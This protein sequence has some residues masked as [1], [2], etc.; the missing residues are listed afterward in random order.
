MLSILICSSKPGLLEQVKDNINTT[1]GVEYELLFIDNR[2]FNKG[3]CS[4]Y[5]TLADMAKYQHLCFLHE[6][7]LFQTKG[8]G[9]I[10]I[11]IFS[12]DPEIGLIGLA[13]CKYKS[14]YFSGWFSNVKELD[15]A[16]YIH[17]YETGVEKVFLSPSGD[18]SLQ[19]VVCIDGVFM[20][21]KKEAWNLN[22]FNEGLLKGFH[23][24]DIDFSLNIAHH[25]KVMVT[26]DLELMHITSGGDYGNNWVETAMKYHQFMKNRLP[27]SKI[28]V[29]L[30][31]TD[32]E[33]I[34]ATLD[35]LK[36][37]KISISNKIKWLTLQKLYLFPNFYYSILK[38]LFYN[39]L[40]LRHIHYLL[41]SKND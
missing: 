6:D 4:V 15:C 25:Y 11:D 32:K 19:E 13:G 27:Y 9:K 20:C 40:G 26:Y 12:S 31:V 8:W 3:I 10:I 36:N 16:N 30:K 7:I 38:F 17:K 41:R 28:P 39:P 21:C 1:V 24:Y 22:K 35:F 34:K 18:K 37:H 5:N 14:S 29:E 33:V 23:F 2:E